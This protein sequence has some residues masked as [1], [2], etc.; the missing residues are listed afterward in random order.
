M[1][2]RDTGRRMDLLD[3]IRQSIGDIL[4]T[5]IGTRVQREDYGSLLPE[6]IDQPLNEA[7][8]LRIAAAAVI[9]IA[10]W[11]PRVDLQGAEINVNPAA[12][13]LQVLIRTRVNG[14]SEEFV[15]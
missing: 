13:G 14:K 12:D 5:S 11:E 8:R 15:I 4:Y 2:S 6:L 1:M 3:H 9:A 7:T 10:E